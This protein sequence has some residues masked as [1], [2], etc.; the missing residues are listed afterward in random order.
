VH[1][2]GVG[3]ETILVGEIRGKSPHPQAS[4]LTVVELFDGQQTLTVVLRRQQPPPI[5]GKVAFAPIGATLPGGL[6]IAPASSGAW[7]RR[8]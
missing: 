8:A 2:K 3:L 6:E 7:P 5:G 4:K 1:P